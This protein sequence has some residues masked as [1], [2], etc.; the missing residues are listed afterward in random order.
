[1]HFPGPVSGPAQGTGRGHSMCLTL[2]IGK[3]WTR[4][5]LST[6]LH[7]SV[8]YFPHLENGV[9]DSISVIA[10]IISLKEFM[11][12]KGLA[13]CLGRSK[14]SVRLS[15]NADLGRGNIMV[16]KTDVASVFTE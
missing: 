12:R 8:P 4:V 13:R 2:H 6:F 14:H 1:M 9:V 10:Y 16:S 15:C 5:T 7:F 11:P 3:E